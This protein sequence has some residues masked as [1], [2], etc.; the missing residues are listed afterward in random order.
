MKQ[1]TKQY[2]L[3]LIESRGDFGMTVNR[4]YCPQLKD[5]YALRKLLK[6]GKLR[7]VRYGTTSSRRTVLF[8]VK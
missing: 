3:D 6:A 1:T 7:R 4:K 8:L 5:H 2:W